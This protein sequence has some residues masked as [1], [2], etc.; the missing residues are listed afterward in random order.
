M[1]TSD[2]STKHL[3]V[4]EEKFP[5]IID[6]CAEIAIRRHNHQVAFNTTNRT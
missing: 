1:R 6:K 3:Y 5:C 2:P 4:A